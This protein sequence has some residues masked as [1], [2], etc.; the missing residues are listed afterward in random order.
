MNLQE[1]VIM[2]ILGEGINYNELPSDDGSIFMKSMEVLSRAK[3]ELGDLR[4]YSY[5]ERDLLRY[6]EKVFIEILVPFA[7]SGGFNIGKV[8]SFT[9]HHNSNRS[10]KLFLSSFLILINQLQNLYSDELLSV[11]SKTGETAFSRAS[12]KSVKISRFILARDVN[13]ATIDSSFLTPQF[14]HE[15]LVLDMLLKGINPKGPGFF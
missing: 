2:T 5:I 14:Y 10:A 8:F 12:H 7:E 1:D 6:V 13:V 11:K 15:E 3:N 9:Y 4:Y